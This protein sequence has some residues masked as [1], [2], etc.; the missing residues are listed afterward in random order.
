MYILHTNTLHTQQKTS[1]I[2]QHGVCIAFICIQAQTFNS[3]ERYWTRHSYEPFLHFKYVDV[4]LLWSADPQCL[5]GLRHLYESC[6]Y[7]DKYGMCTDS[8]TPEL[9]CSVS[10][11]Q[12]FHTRAS[13]S[14]ASSANC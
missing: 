7:S 11:L 2:I 8:S 9:E 12:C 5:F 1:M 6:F 4:Y 13:I 3:Y 10:S 14:L